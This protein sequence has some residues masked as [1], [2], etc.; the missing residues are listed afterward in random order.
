MMNDTAKS[1]LLEKLKAQFMVK[2]HCG[3]V[4]P[5]LTFEETV[6]LIETPK[7][8]EHC[9]KYNL[10]TLD[11][12]T[13]LRSEAPEYWYIEQE[14]VNLTN[15][16]TAILVGAFTEDATIIVDGTND[17]HIIMLHG[18]TAHIIARD[19][20]TIRIDR[21]EDTKTTITKEGKNAFIYDNYYN[22][23]G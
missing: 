20:A 23:K 4:T 5:Q 3:M 7:G 18:A 9:T 11:L 17:A 8:V 6:K 15:P 14:G 21:A 2:G 13:A 1:I 19:F 12:L 10:P 22:R 16:T